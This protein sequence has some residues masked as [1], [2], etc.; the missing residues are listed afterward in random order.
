MRRYSFDYNKVCFQQGILGQNPRRPSPPSQTCKP[1]WRADR[2]RAET[3]IVRE[4][5]SKESHLVPI[6]CPSQPIT[7]LFCLYGFLLG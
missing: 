6:R 3:V 1:C 2:R 4:P 5:G 7:E